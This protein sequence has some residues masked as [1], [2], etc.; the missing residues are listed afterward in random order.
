MRTIPIFARRAC[1][2]MAFCVFTSLVL[3]SAPLIERN[4]AVKMRDGIILRADIYRPAESGRFPVIL[5]RTPYDKSTM[6][7]FGLKAAELGYVAIIQDCRGR[8]ASAGDW[9][10]LANEFNDGYDTVEWAAALAYSNGKVGLFGGSYGGF[11]T[12][13]GALANPPH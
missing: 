5:Q 11:T 10:P 3:A 8:Y 6:S 2:A 13:M 12:L 1:K 4:A 7:S 9:Y